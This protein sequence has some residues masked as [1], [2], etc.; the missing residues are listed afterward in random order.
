[1]EREDAQRTRS[2]QLCHAGNE[3]LGLG[4]SWNPETGDVR[5]STL[6]AQNTYRVIHSR[7]DRCRNQIDYIL[8]NQRYCNGILNSKVRQSAECASDH[9][10]VVIIT[11]TKLKAQ[12]RK[13]TPVRWNLE[14]LNTIKEDYTKTTDANI[15]MYQEKEIDID[16]RW[17][18]IKDT[19]KESA[20]KTIGKK[21]R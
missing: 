1:M 7:G 14:A 6:K 17:S 16:L 2:P 18:K 9:K 8:C 19:I 12:G 21:R 4:H 13:S 11:R 5:T 10:P 15:S 3:E 20:T